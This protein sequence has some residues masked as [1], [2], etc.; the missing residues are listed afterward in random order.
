MWKRHLGFSISF[1]LIAI[2]VLF[3]EI[4][5]IAEIRLFIKPLI[6][7]LLLAYLVNKTRLYGSFSKLIFGGLLFSLA[8]DIALLFAGKSATFFLA[9]LGAFL[10]AH[11][12]YCAAFFRDYKYDPQ[13]SRK[14]GN[15]MLFV[16]GLFTISFYLWIRSYL[17]GMEIPVMAYMFVIS[18]MAILA[19]YRYGRVNLLSFQL[20][21]TGAILFIISDTL[22]AINKFV[23]P[24]QYSGVFIMATYMVAQYLI[25][26]GTLERVVPSKK[27]VYP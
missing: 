12:F 7:V 19:G 14:Y 6:C 10:L 4:L 16:M 1:C 20:I 17:N 8:G 27:D 5:D 9:G 15:I 24:F 26:M 13:A 11:L 3:V 23:S 22:L 2:L 25:T 21:F 18:L